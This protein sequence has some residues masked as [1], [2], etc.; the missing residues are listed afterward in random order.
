MNFPLNK[1]LILESMHSRKHLSV[2]LVPGNVPETRKEK[3]QEYLDK[4]FNEL[5]IH[6][7]WQDCR[8]FAREL[9]TRWEAFNRGT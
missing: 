4:Y 7:Y 9:R 3:A 8:E 2:Q 5:D 1:G 6:V